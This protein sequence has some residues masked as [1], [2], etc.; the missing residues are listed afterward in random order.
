VPSHGR[1]VPGRAEVAQCLRDYRDAISF[2]Y[3]LPGV[4]AGLVL[5]T[6]QVFRIHTPVAVAASTL[7]AAAL[8]N[9]VRQR[10]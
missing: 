10:A 5:L 4:H 6:T 9:P 7:A 3:D 2:T 8:F 1:L